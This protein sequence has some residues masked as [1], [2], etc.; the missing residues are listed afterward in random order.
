M[1][2]G[3]LMGIVAGGFGF[4][5]WV[6][7][8]NLGS[9]RGRTIGQLRERGDWLEVM[10]S[11]R[12]GAPERM[13]VDILHYCL[14]VASVATRRVRLTDFRASEPGDTREVGG[15]PATPRRTP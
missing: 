8:Y 6:L 9:K 12:T 4:A 1:N 11:I 14:L 15:S 7:G 2:E 3:V 10:R 5:S 13:R